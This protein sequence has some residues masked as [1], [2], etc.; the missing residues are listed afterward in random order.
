MR[1]GAEVIDDDRLGALRGER[2]G[3]GTRR[4]VV[5]R[6]IAGG[7]DEDARHR[8][9]SYR[10][11]RRRSRRAVFRPPLFVE[12]SS[13]SG[14]RSACATRYRLSIVIDFSPRSTSPMN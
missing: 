1:A 5:P 9:L 14:V 4:L 6:A 2:P 7:E 10:R 12:A 13:P 3:E 8:V 11:Q